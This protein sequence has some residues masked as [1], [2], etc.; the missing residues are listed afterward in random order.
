MTCRQVPTLSRCFA[1]AVFQITCIYLSSQLLDCVMKHVEG[2]VEA[3]AKNDGHD[4]AEG[5]ISS[6]QKLVKPG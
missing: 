1:D 5:V 2:E 4:V 6:K 3:E